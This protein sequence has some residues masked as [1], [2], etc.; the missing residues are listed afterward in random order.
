MESIK[1]FLILGTAGGLTGWFVY[2]ILKKHTL[3]NLWGAII[4][5]IIG[6]Y[7]GHFS[8]KPLMEWITDLFD[9][10]NV[11]YAIVGA[12]SVVW[13]LTKVSPGKH[14]HY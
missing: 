13:I 12:F 1:M 9:Q 6:A 4:V 7:I 14:K 3:G 5:G 8:L 11:I 10:V 2:S